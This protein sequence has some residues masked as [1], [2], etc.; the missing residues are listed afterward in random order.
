MPRRPG[1][2]S[3][4]EQTPISPLQRLLISSEPAT[5]H[6]RGCC[7]HDNKTIRVRSTNM[8]LATSMRSKLARIPVV[9]PML[10][11]PSPHERPSG[12]SEVQPLPNRSCVCSVFTSPTSTDS[13]CLVDSSRLRNEHACFQ[14]D[15]AAFVSHLRQST[16]SGTSLFISTERVIRLPRQVRH[17]QIVP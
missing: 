7:S 15:L 6:F 9:A 4:A 14:S 1:F 16:L 13:S 2:Q 11:A 10:G 8:E 12:S 3:M 5:A 17:C